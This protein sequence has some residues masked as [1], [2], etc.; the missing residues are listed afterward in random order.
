MRRPSFTPIAVRTL[1]LRQSG[2][3]V[4]KVQVR[5]G[6]PAPWDEMAEACPVQMLGLGRDRVHHIAGVDGVQALELSLQFVEQMLAGY[7]EDHPGER[8]HWL[9]DSGA[10][11]FPRPT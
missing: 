2:R 4:R 9:K 1:W 11:Y 5:I 10:V 3:R 6:A 7:E 8:L